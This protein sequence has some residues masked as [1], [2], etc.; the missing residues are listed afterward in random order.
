MLVPFRT[1]LSQAYR[2]KL[3]DNDIEGRF[4]GAQ[5]IAD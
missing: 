3:A 4:I 5:E 1:S 2:E